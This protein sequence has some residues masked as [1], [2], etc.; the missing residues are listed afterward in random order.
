V[1]TTTAGEYKLFKKW[2]NILRDVL[3]ITYHT[4]GVGGLPVSH[5]AISS[6][7]LGLI[8]AFSDWVEK[9]RR[10]GKKRNVYKHEDTYGEMAIYL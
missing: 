2:R 8:F 5:F 6:P 10:Y 3:Q 1:P 4:L 9:D 7:N